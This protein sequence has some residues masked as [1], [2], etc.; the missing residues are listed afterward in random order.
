MLL[1]LQTLLPIL[2]VFLHSHFYISLIKKGKG[3]TRGVAHD[4]VSFEGSS[5]G[6]VGCES[7]LAGRV[8]SL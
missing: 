3:S 1:L 5:H 4:G 8:L 2:L 7:E 6:L